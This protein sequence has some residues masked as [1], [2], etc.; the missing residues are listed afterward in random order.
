MGIRC[1]IAI[2][3]CVAIELGSPAK[4]DGAPRWPVRY[5]SSSSEI[6]SK[7]SILLVEVQ[8]SRIDR[9]GLTLGLR[10][11]E[12]VAGHLALPAGHQLSIQI[13]SESFDDRDVKLMVEERPSVLVCLSNVVPHRVIDSGLSFFESIVPIQIKKP[14]DYEMFRMSIQRA[15]LHYSIYV[16]YNDVNTSHGSNVD[17]RS[18]PKLSP[19]LFTTSG[20]HSASYVG[21]TRV[22][23]YLLNSSM[24]N[25]NIARLILSNTDVTDRGVLSIP[26]ELAIA[27]V[28]CRSTSISNAAISHFRMFPRLSDVDLSASRVTADGLRGLN[29]LQL[30]RV[31]VNGLGLSANDLIPLKSSKGLQVLEVCET[32]VGD[33]LWPLLSS[34]PILN[35]LDASRTKVGRGGDGL[36]QATGLEYLFLNETET[37]DPL[38]LEIQN[39]RRLKTLSLMKTPITDAG[40]LALAKIESLEHLYLNYCENVTDVGL[41]HLV[42]LKNLRSL[43]LVGTAATYRGIAE[44]KKKIGHPV[45]MEYYFP[46]VVYPPR[47][48]AK[49]ALSTDSAP[50]SS[51]R[52]QNGRLVLVKPAVF[53]F[54]PTLV[55][56]HLVGTDRVLSA[57]NDS[58]RIEVLILAGSDV[59]K[60][61]LK[62]LSRFDKVKTL[63]VS[64]TNTDDDGLR[65]IVRNTDLSELQMADT[66]I[67]DTGLVQL[68]SEK[69]LRKM[70]L[71]GINR[72]TD[73]GVRGLKGLSELEELRFYGAAGITDGSIETFAKM[74]KLRRLSLGGTGVRGRELHQLSGLPH[75]E[76]LSLERSRIDDDSLASISQIRTL[77]SLDLR[78][79]QVT[80]ARVLDLKRLENLESLLLDDTLITDESLVTLRQLK[81]LKKL[82]VSGTKVTANGLLEAFGSRVEP[83]I[84][85]GTPPQSLNS[86]R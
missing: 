52:M 75:L 32:N 21:M 23:D 31:A 37:S 19:S 43:E 53:D 49:P 58:R 12:T 44:F 59:T 69:Q 26:S 50:G 22:D 42:R 35:V 68:E 74:K 64:Q 33:D 81:R 28:E 16:A 46:P 70:S 7:N 63:D 6:W 20:F 65:E 54:P 66:D 60:M 86:S 72:I 27:Q 73:A 45:R 9:T 25:S 82:T 71:S 39:H 55:C 38:L 34:W 77:V 29:S 48:L 51:S 76:N 84:H 3:C 11:R 41:G 40:L 67:T 30:R 78:G 56:A 5:H 18:P 79:T 24:R 15:R 80:G 36:S 17:T 62:E 14:N 4:S 47:E 57:F 85:F 13:E 61:G 8:S 10:Y 2:L 1:V 83:E